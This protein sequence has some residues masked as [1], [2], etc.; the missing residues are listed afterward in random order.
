MKNFF[1]AALFANNAKTTLI[2]AIV[3]LGFVALGC[4]GSGN[5]AK[6][7]PLP[8]EYLGGWQS[9]D[10]ASLQLT[11]NNEGNYRNGGTTINGAAAE[12]D[13]TGKIL[14]LSFLGVSVKEFKIDQA[15]KDGAMKLDG[16]LYKNNFVKSGG[17]DTSSSDNSD[18]SSKDSGNATMPSDSDLQ[19]LASS[20]VMEFNDAVQK[21]DFTEFIDTAGSKQFKEQFPND[22]LKD[23]FKVFIDKK[24][25]FGELVKGIDGI[26][27]NYDPKP[28][29]TT[30]SGFKI[31]N[32]AGTFPTKPSGI[33]FRFKYVWQNNEWKLL[34]INLKA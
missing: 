16:V 4:G 30:D 20:T 3:V 18:T 34:S 27:P 32:V 7:K 19:D 14:K 12:V 33:E 17:N 1:K 6:A 24:K 23:N 15:P 31:L 13:D 29:I 25:P 9:A 11:S 22:K 28:E 21:E 2:I 5:T 8:P 26:K 10:G